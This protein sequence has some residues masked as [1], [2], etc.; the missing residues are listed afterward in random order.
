M[1][2]VRFEMHI[3]ADRHAEIRGLMESGG[4]KTRKELFNVALTLFDWAVR[5]WGAG[6]KVVSIDDAQGK[7]RELKMPGLRITPVTP[8]V[9]RRRKQ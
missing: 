8:I 2:K 7:I 3:S 4:L 6:R 9:P 1:A 5:E